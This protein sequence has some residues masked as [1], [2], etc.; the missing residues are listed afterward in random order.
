MKV[1][2]C[3]LVSGPKIRPRQLR[4]RITNPASDTRLGSALQFRECILPTNR[5]DVVAN[6]GDVAQVVDLRDAGGREFHVFWT[7]L[8]H[9]VRASSAGDFLRLRCSKYPPRRWLK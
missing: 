1:N 4:N 6:A 3:L 5:S 2:I 8:M 9:A 7:Q